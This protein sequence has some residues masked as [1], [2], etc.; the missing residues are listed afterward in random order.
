MAD[1]KIKAV[2]TADDRA[3]DTLRKFG[4][5]TDR[6]NRGVTRAAKAAAIGL[7]AVGAAAVAFGVSAVKAFSESENAMAQT[8]AVLKSTKGVAGVTADQ[9]TKLANSLQ[10]VTRYSD[11]TIQTGENLLLTFTKIG[12]D[13]F[14]QATE[15][16]LD[17]STALGQDVKAS[18]IQ[19]GKALQDPILGVTALRRVGVNFSSAQRDVIQKLVETGRAGEAQKLILK[20]LQTE[21]GGSAKAAGET[22]A[23][24]LDILKN[25]FDNVKESIG[26]VI[27]GALT[28]LMAKLANFVASEQFQMW[29][30]KT[31]VWLQTNLPIA[32]NYIVNT[33]IPSLINIFNALWPTIKVVLAAFAAL[34][35]FL[36]ENT[37]IVKALAAAFVALKVAMLIKGAVSAFTAGMAT[38]RGS[39]AVTKGA[40]SG[41]R[42]LVSKRM[43]MGGITIAAALWAL[44][45]VYNAAIAVR[46]AIR[47]VNNAAGASAGHTRSQSAAMGRLQ[48]LMKNGT[49]AQRR[50]A[51]KAMWAQNASGTDFF[52]GGTSLVGERGPEM[53]ELPRGSKVHQ[54]D[55]T[56][57]MMGSNTT[58]NISVPMMTGSAGERRKVARLLLRD[59][60][61]IADMSGKSVSDL[62]TKQGSM[63]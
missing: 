3:S 35:K 25:Q 2:I 11:E 48:H 6:L 20:E 54:A 43:V 4:N 55:R 50:R 51:K 13:I 33:L 22:F 15:V 9:V 26:Q 12:K 21:F 5:N 39:I 46:D 19:L 45:N 8:N 40:V 31:T 23:G 14:P 47:D 60:Q 17:M 61:D 7:V 37:W 24:K 30:Q 34:I 59:L 32:I 27:V 16:M 57:K 58:I 36:G 63:A 42:N 18:A 41:L 10:N 52:P 1:A 38:V 28:P 62:L 53:V 56:R 49:P 44:D 29:L